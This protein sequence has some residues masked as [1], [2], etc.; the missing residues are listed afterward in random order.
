MNAKN[1]IRSG[2]DRRQLFTFL[3]RERRRR[4]DSDR[5][6]PVSVDPAPLSG[7]AKTANSVWDSARNYWKKIFRP[8]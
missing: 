1:S 5:R 3:V 6:T 8:D 2:H 4:T 7:E